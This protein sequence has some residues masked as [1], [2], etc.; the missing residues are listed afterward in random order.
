MDVSELLV[1]LNKRGA[2]KYK[3]DNNFNLVREYE[4]Y[5]SYLMMDAYI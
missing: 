1:A 5:P 4:R 3:L 2:L